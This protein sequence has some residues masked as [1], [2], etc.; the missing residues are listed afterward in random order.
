MSIFSKAVRSAS[1]SPATAI[2][3]AKHPTKTTAMKRLGIGRIIVG[4]FRIRGLLIA[5]PDPNVTCRVMVTF[6][7]R[8]CRLSHL[9]ALHNKPSKSVDKIRGYAL[10]ISR[11]IR[12]G[13]WC[14]ELATVF[15][16]PTLG[17]CGK[18]VRL[19]NR[20][21]CSARQHSGA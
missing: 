10:L 11:L 20:C 5:R 9:I 17:G 21:A 1:I 3:T 15:D 6:H 18:A 13:L 12:V 4:S 14:A 19:K 2:A 7:G 8:L 16:K